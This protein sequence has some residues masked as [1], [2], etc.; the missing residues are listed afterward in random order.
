MARSIAAVLIGYIAMTAW[1]RLSFEVLAIVLGPLAERS[2]RQSL[3]S[4]QGDPSIFFTRPI[5]LAC[6]LIATALVL[7][8]VY[9]KIKRRKAAAEEG[10][11]T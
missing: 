6:I 9:Q 1:V 10:Q 4:S 8:P 5:S 3:L 2:L 7:V 11:E